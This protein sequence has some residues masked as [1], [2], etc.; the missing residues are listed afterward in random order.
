MVRLIWILF[1]LHFS[2]SPHQP[3]TSSPQAA[4]RV[5]GSRSTG[6]L[7]TLD[8]R[9]VV[10]PAGRALSP[11]S[12]YTYSSSESSNNLRGTLFSRLSSRKYPVFEWQRLHY[13]QNIR[14]EHQS[15]HSPFSC[16]GM[17]NR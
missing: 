11:H 1:V 8:A 4:E 7:A 15:Y 13:L 10:C 16:S 3:T 6:L 2:P 9:K 5:R 12:P 14:F 17:D